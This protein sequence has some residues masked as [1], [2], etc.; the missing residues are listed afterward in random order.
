MCGICGVAAPSLPGGAEDDV[1][2]MAARLAH[3]GPG[4]RRVVAR[5]GAVLGL[6]RLHVVAPNAP[7]GPHATADGS[8]VAP[9][10]GAAYRATDS[11]ETGVADT[12]GA[13]ALDA[14]GNLAVANSTG[15][16][17]YKHPGRVGDTPIIGCGLYADDTL[18]AAACRVVPL[19]DRPSSAARMRAAR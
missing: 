17:F 8:V 9:D 1:R 4:D 18:G 19:T 15:G 3:R 7:G 11:V 5:A 6:A 10:A 13:V 2:A 12:V 14:S 16:T